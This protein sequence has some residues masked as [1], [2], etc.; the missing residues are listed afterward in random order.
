MT[1]LLIAFAIVIGG[2]TTAVGIVPQAPAHPVIET[3]CH[4]DEIGM[5]MR[6]DFQPAAHQR[7][8]W[9]GDRFYRLCVPLD[10]LTLNAEGRLVPAYDD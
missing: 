7:G 3:P 9:D 1:S 4:E 6:F 5:V 10:N 8:Y 2:G